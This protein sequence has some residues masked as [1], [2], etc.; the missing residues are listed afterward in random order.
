MKKSHARSSLIPDG[1]MARPVVFRIKSIKKDVTLER[2]ELFDLNGVEITF[3][4]P[5]NV[6]LFASIANKEKQ[7]AKNIYSSLITKNIKIKKDITIKNEDIKRLYNYLEH[8]QTSII[9]IYTAVESFAN[10]AIPQDYIYTFKNNKGITESYDKT[11]IERW[12]KTSE[13]ITELLP[14]ILNSSSPKQLPT[15]SLFKELET[16][17]NDII[18]Q[19]T[20]ITQKKNTTGGLE[21]NRDINSKFIGKL[22]KP[23]IFEII[24]SGF[25]L[26]KFFCEKDIFHSFFP[27]GFSSAQ[28]KPIEIQNFGD[29][30]QLYRSAEDKKTK[31]EE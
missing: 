25:D 12:L 2:S 9:A 1:R 23:N 8:I 4:T 30:F 13:K 21:I 20:E 7:Q 28:M 6:A 26:I 15:W 27:L 5:N 24:E 18:H 17:R 31:I 10:I 16:I 29:Q 14:K 3:P 22:L 11:A 19:K